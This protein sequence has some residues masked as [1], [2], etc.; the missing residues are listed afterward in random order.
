MKFNLDSKKMLGYAATA[1]AL[2]GMV[3]NSK[4]A[5]NQRKDMK[6]ELKEEVVKEVLNQT[7]GN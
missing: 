5:E 2:I 1:A 7:K 3:L 4:V 6:K